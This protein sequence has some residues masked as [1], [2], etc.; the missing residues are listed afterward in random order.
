VG[1][2]HDEGAIEWCGDGIDGGGIP[3]GAPDVASRPKAIYP[4]LADGD[5]PAEIA[6]MLPGFA[7]R[8]NVCRVMAHDLALLRSWAGFRDHVVVRSALGAQRSEVAILRVR[9]R[10]GASYE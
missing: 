10:L 5:W 1:R 8:L 6:D 3:E 2:R 4:P 7:G 9:H